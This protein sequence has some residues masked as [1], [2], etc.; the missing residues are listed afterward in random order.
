MTNA[1][2]FFL[3]KVSS[4]R[5]KTVDEETQHDCST[6][7]EFV[8][9]NVNQEDVELLV[10]DIAATPTWIKGEIKSV[11]F[12]QA[13]KDSV[14]DEDP[15]SSMVIFKKSDNKTMLLPMSYII[16]IQCGNLKNK[17]TKKIRKHGL[18][19]CYINNSDP[20]CWASMKYLTFGITWVPSY[21]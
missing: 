12:D 13:I 17:F 20:D 7:E 14:D 18:E 8:R 1:Y 5:A 11:V 2:T 3:V 9:A 19:I 15:K 16:S 21:Q 10:K 4:I 6:T